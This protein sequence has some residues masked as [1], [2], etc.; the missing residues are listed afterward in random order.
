MRPTTPATTSSP[1]KATACSRAIRSRNSARNLPPRS[2]PR[3]ST[4]DA[5]LNAFLEACV[6]VSLPTARASAGDMEAAVFAP[7]APPMPWRP[8]PAAPVALSV[9]L[10]LN[11]GLR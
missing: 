1:G 8:S 10:A 7:P 2:V 6:Q 9:A 5:E 3:G 4:L 11:L